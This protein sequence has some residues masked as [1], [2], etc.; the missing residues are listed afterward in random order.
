MNR[1]SDSRMNRGCKMECG[2]G[3]RNNPAA[4]HLTGIYRSIWLL[5]W[6]KPRKRSS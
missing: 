2:S 1:G 4:A 3:G 5:A 6:S